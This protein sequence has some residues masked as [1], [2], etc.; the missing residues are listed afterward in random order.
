MT[1]VTMETSSSTE[2]DNDMSTSDY[3]GA[4][5]LGPAVVEIDLLKDALGI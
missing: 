1:T 3:D 2:N 4:V 5:Q